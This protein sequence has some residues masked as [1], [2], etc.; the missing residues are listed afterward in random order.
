MFPQSLA[1]DSRSGKLFAANKRVFYITQGGR[2]NI[3]VYK[4]DIAVID[5][6]A[7]AILPSIPAS[8]PNLIR[9]P[10][11]G[12]VFS[13]NQPM[14]L[15]SSELTPQISAQRTLPPTLCS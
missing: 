8:A 11:S 4:Y 5:P 2:N 7:P 10:G 13:S 15:P 14:A 6:Q 3:P 1:Y 9:T 12:G